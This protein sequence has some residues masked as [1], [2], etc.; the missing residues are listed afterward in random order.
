LKRLDEQVQNAAA[1]IRALPDHRD[2]DNAVT[3][4]PARPHAIPDGGGCLLG[5][6]CLGTPMPCNIG[7]QP[8]GPPTP[9]IGSGHT[10]QIAAASRDVPSLPAAAS[11]TDAKPG[12]CLTRKVFAD[13]RQRASAPFCTS[14]FFEIATAEC[15]GELFTEFWSPGMVWADDPE[16]A[17]VFTFMDQSNGSM[18]HAIYLLKHEEFKDLPLVQQKLFRLRLAFFVSRLCLPA[19]DW[20]LVHDDSILAVRAPHSFMIHQLTSTNFTLNQHEIA[21]LW[22]FYSATVAQSDRPSYGLLKQTIDSYRHETGGLVAAPAPTSQAYRAMPRLLADKNKSTFFTFHA[23]TYS[24]HELGQL[25][26]VTDV[27]PTLEYHLQSCWMECAVNSF[28]A[29]PKT[30]QVTYAGREDPSPVAQVFRR[31]LD[32][33]LVYGRTYDNMVPIIEC[34]RCGV[35]PLFGHE[36]TSPPILGHGGY[37]SDLF[38][39]V[40]GCNLTWG[41]MG[42][43]DVAFP[44]FLDSVGLTHEAV[45]FDPPSSADDTST[46]ASTCERADTADVVLVSFGSTVQ[47]S[48]VFPLRVKTACV[49]CV[50]VVFGNGAHYFSAIKGF[51][52]ESWTIKDALTGIF[53]TYTSFDAASKAAYAPR[54]EAG[55]YS[56]LFAVY[57]RN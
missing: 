34:M 6:L 42:A 13:A 46:Y 3:M 54:K 38:S 18:I 53:R 25:L 12:E 11:V 49:S 52:D 44:R 22:Q 27:L 56:M 2:I 57:A 5:T 9:P 26:S 24:H 30:R 29:V 4:D 55:L 33:M 8:A 39:G 16:A 1:Q 31:L 15:L 51:R 23:Q 20:I 10:A 37:G 21:P 48:D 35:Y 47:P 40:A 28:F 41:E 43:F 45:L 50:A 17:Q 32:V 36:Q 14:K 7:Q 19:F